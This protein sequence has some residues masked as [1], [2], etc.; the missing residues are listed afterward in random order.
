MTSTALSND[1]R[2]NLLDP[3]D[4]RDP[5]ARGRIASSRR[6]SCFQIRAV[7]LPDPVREFR[8]SQER[9][10]RADF[11]WPELRLLVEVEG[12]I[13][14]KGRHTRGSGYMRD[15]E[16]YKNPPLAWMSGWR[17]LRFVDKHIK[18]GYAIN[19]LEAVIRKGFE[20]NV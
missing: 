16:K 17:V 13:W 3:R 19:T 2:G 10:F 20:G 7:G 1:P 8:F 14:K 15:V 11:A 9:K 18:S 6:C 4:P 12:G 5:R